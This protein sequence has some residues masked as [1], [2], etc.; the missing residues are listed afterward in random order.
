MVYLL[1]PRPINKLKLGN[2]RPDLQN[3]LPIEIGNVTND[4]ISLIDSER[5]ALVDEAGNVVVMIGQ[6]D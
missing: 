2:N 4:E 1:D 5:I 6:F 3:L